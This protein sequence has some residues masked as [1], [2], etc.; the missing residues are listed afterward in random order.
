M[1]DRPPGEVLD[2]ESGEKSSYGAQGAEDAVRAPHPVRQ[3][4]PYDDRDKDAVKHPR[5]ELHALRNTGADERKGDR[6]E[7]CLEQHEHAGRNPIQRS[8]LG[9]KGDWPSGFET[10]TKTEL[11]WLANEA[12]DCLGIE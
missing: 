2:T 3:K 10:G 9:V 6:S 4:G 8:A 5:A 12:S 1:D 7:H 11:E